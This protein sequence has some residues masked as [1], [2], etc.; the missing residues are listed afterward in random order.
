[1]EKIKKCLTSVNVFHLVF[2]LLLIIATL[3]FLQN[4]KLEKLLFINHYYSFDDK[5]VDDSVYYHNKKR[6]M[7]DDHFDDFNID[8]KREFIMINKVMEERIR[9]FDE[10]IKRFDSLNLELNKPE[11]NNR[12]I[13]NKIKSKD[14]EIKKFVYY[15][16]IEQ[17]ENEFILKMKLANNIKKEDIKVNLQN[18]N[19]IVRIEKNNSFEDKTS[20]THFYSSYFENFE[21]PNTKAV[22]KDLNINVENNELI[23]IV[24]IIK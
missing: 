23:V 12:E 1:M 3:L 5:L 15:P 20:K 9:H 8:L 2:L 22:E 11:E 21:V 14:R 10:I 16:K 18:N 17:N 19:L 7:I 13:S 24:P 6:P 4:K